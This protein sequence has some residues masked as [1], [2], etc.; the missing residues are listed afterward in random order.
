MKKI[1]KAI[2]FKDVAF[3]FDKLI[4]K[5][6]SV[7]EIMLMEVDTSVSDFVGGGKWKCLVQLQ[8]NLK[9]LILF[10]GR[11]DFAQVA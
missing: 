3:M 11:M 1:E 5:G 7:E 8:K 6:L 10:V 2:T 9:R 4:E